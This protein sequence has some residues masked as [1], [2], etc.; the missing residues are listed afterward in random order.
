MK[1]KVI[2]EVTLHPETLLNFLSRN[3]KLEKEFGKE[4]CLPQRNFL[5]STVVAFD[6]ET[7]Y[8]ACRNVPVELREGDD[9]SEVLK[10]SIKKLFEKSKFNDNLL[11]K[12]YKK[13]SGEHFERLLCFVILKILEKDSSGVEALWINTSNNQL[14]TKEW[15]WLLQK[16]GTALMKSLLTKSLIFLKLSANSFLQVAGTPI[17]TLARNL[18][19]FKRK[20]NVKKKELQSF[21][22]NDGSLF[23]GSFSSNNAGF[24]KKNLL[25][26]INPSKKQSEKLLRHIFL[27]QPFCLQQKEKGK[28]SR[29]PKRL[30]SLIPIFHTLIKKSKEVSY[31]LI[32]KRYCPLPSS[33]DDEQQITKLELKDVVNET[34]NDH[35]VWLFI[36]KVCSKLIPKK[37]FGSKHNF[38]IFKNGVLRLITLRRYE[39]FPLN[40]I[41]KK[42]RTKDFECFKVK[43]AR[44]TLTDFKKRRELSKKL[45]F[46]IFQ[47]IVSPLLKNNFYITEKANHKQKM[48]FYRKKV[49]SKL[50]Q[51]ALQSLQQEPTK[52]LR[53]LN[54]ME[55]ENVIK[56]GKE[57]SKLRFIP[58]EKGVRPIMNLKNQNARVYNALSVLYNE[59]SNQPHLFGASVFNYDEIYSKYLNFVS[60]MKNLASTYGLQGGYTSIP[61]YVVCVDVSK[62][63]D[64]INQTKM[65][66][67]IEKIL[68]KEEY[69]VQ[70][71][72]LVLPCIGRTQT[73]SKRTSFPSK[74]TLQFPQYALQLSELGNIRNAVIHDDVSLTLLTKQAIFESIKQNISQNIVSCNGKLFL[75][76]NGIPQGS[77]LSS[78]LCSLFYG[79]MERNCLG[80]LPTNCPFT[81]LPT[82]PQLLTPLLQTH[83]S[84]TPPPLLLPSL[85]SHP[86][87]HNILTPFSSTESKQSPKKKRRMEEKESEIQ[88]PVKGLLM[89]FIDDFLYLSNSKEAA[90]SFLRYMHKGNEEYGCKIN[91]DKTKLNFTCQVSSEKTLHAHQTTLIP[92]CGFLFDSVTLEILADYSKLLGSR[93]QSFFN[94]LKHFYLSYSM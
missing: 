70:K 54:H 8:Q 53:P 94:F 21:C 73:L 26:K 13:N 68:K 36:I 41:L 31:S 40:S 77:V 45:I 18:A 65:E 30:I 47:D 92:W 2:K 44:S 29:N 80:F 5:E 37:L 61:F 78:L 57:T 84:L 82:P 63:F 28:M 7:N 85:S 33:F 20:T 4:E 48:F 91:T 64:T 43:G 10:W 25:S 3:P 49:W 15:E 19:G 50:T 59:K 52:L 9:Q 93:L 83:S 90:S 46:W 79:D 51:L 56:S 32:L 11:C 16:I 17:S 42:L 58:K 89:R 39:K 87:P 35:N 34:V 38:G 14:V 23:Y 55:T 81:P 76:V 24:N 86:T 71:Y 60:E 66:E 88:V 69:N 22:F 62:A 6:C 27:G 75:Q 72:S 12:G 1:H 74:V 67:I